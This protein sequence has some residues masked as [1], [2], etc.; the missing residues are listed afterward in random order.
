MNTVRLIH[1]DSLI[2]LKEFEDCSIDVVVTDPPYEISFAAKSWD[3]SGIAFS[4]EIWDQWPTA[5]G[6]R[7]HTP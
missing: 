2:K 4:H 3:G 7:S 6:F 5:Q 1:G